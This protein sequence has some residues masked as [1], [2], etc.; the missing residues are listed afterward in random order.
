MFKCVV[1]LKRSPFFIYCL[2]EE[3]GLNHC[4]N[5]VDQVVGVVVSE[6]SL[7]VKEV[8]MAPMI[9]NREIKALESRDDK[10]LNEACE[11]IKHELDGELDKAVEEFDYSQ[12]ED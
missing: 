2:N 11:S 5:F 3:E 9:A 8:K 12:I 1:I 10:D 7:E 6:T 4:K